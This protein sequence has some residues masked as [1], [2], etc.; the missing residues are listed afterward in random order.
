VD[1]VDVSGVLERLTANAKDAE[2]LGSILASSD[3]L[4]SEGC[5]ADEAVLKKVLE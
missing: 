3:T 5:M 4:K 1:L 2:Y